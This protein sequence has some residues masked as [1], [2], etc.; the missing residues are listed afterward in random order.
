MGF[1]DCR[2]QHNRTVWMRRLYE[3]YGAKETATNEYIDGSYPF[4][5]ARHRS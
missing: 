2:I 1:P 3:F 5:K 4:T